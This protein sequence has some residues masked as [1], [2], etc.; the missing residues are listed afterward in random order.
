MPVCLLAAGKVAVVA[1]SAF[2]LSWTHSVERTE[3]REEWRLMPAG[4]E[5]VEA[6]VQGS[7]AGM[8]PP[9]GSQLQDGWWVYAPALPA[10]ARLVLASSGATGAGW[11]L[12]GEGRCTEVG[13][14]AGE[15]AVI[16]VCE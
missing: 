2:T 9:E 15:P 4:L 1:A 5:L 10:Q 3:W 14:T 8:E 16:E 7:G 12:C 11:T 6:R 13:A